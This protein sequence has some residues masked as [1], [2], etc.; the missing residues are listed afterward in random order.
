M[1]DGEIFLKKM[2]AMSM[3]KAELIKNGKDPDIIERVLMNDYDTEKG[4]IS[5]MME[6]IDLDDD[7]QFGKLMEMVNKKI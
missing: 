5:R 2:K 7:E 4:S 6:E 1:K 3:I